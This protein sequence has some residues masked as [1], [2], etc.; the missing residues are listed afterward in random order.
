LNAL[1]KQRPTLLIAEDLHW[2]GEATIDLLDDLSRRIGNTRLLVIGSYRDEESPRTHPLRRLRQRTLPNRS[3]AR[4]ALG[5][6]SR[7]DVDI[8]LAK[9]SNRLPI[10][11]HWPE[12][13]YNRSE[14]NPLFLTQLIAAVLEQDTAQPFD[15]A[16]PGGIRELIRTRLARLSADARSLAFLAAVVGDAFDVDL[17]Q[18]VTA[19]DATRINAALDELLD[20]R[21]IRDTG[22]AEN[23]DYAFAHHLIEATAYAEASSH[24]LRRRHERVALALLELYPSRH[25]ELSYRIAHHFEGGAQPQQAVDFY[26]RA[27]EFALTRFAYDDAAL[28][29]TAALRLASSA[30][31][32][33]RL[34]MIREEAHAR[35]G[36]PARQESDLNAL[37]A[38][39]DAN[40]L[41][42]RCELVRRR[43]NLLHAADRRDE[44][45][46]AIEELVKL[47]ESSRS[48]R[49]GFEARYARARLLMLSSRGA[50]ALLECDEALQRAI[51]AEDATAQRRCY[52]LMADIYDR[53]AEF[54]K[55]HDALA[56][57]E[58]LSSREKD[59]AGQ[60]AVLLMFCRLANWQ[61]RYDDLHHHALSMLEV[62]TACGDR[63]HEGTA[64]NAL[65]VVALYRFEVAQARRYFDRAVEV[66]EALKRPRNVIAARLNQALLLT[67]LGCLD[68][69]FASLEISKKMAEDAGAGLFGEAVDCLIAEVLLRHGDVTKARAVAADALKRSSASGSRNKAT[70]SL[71]LARCDALQGDYHAALGRIDETLRLFATPGLEVQRCDALGDRA[72]IAMQLRSFKVALESVR[73]FLP[74]L[75]AQPLRFAE[76]EALFLTAARSLRGVGAQEEATAH[77]ATA[78]KIYQ[79]RLLQIPERSVRE[80]YAKLWF[81][82][83]LVHERAEMAGEPAALDAR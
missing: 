47:A 11:P 82:R 32:R 62:S 12:L 18:E 80:Q 72:W 8:L 33:R 30:E 50:Q 28:R 69:G 54:S 10:A 66:F 26:A 73:E 43:I 3:V 1:A 61:N 55:A 14:G 75:Q 21:V 57:A 78:W 46:A 2:A 77:L 58:A 45:S 63:A 52:C 7:N 49:A 37:A 56:S 17:L 31:Q 71:K 48:A 6:I 16:L 27:A 68:D 41:G 5:P 4:L 40:D 81:H 70:A 51:V 44:E 34:L 65:G 36:D 76:P 79:E 60:L 20:R 19:W 35:R 59:P 22:M 9:L 25:D 67:R 53:S 42:A 15:E 83:D 64:S 74:T 38:C 39:I 24:D 13:L 29:A 23:G